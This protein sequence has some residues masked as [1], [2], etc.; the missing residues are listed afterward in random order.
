MIKITIYKNPV[1]DYMGFQS[2]GHAGYAD[3][4]QDIVC[5]AVS[6]LVINLVNSL[7]SLT[8]DTFGLTQNEDSG[9]IKVV[10][11]NTLSKEANLLVESF[12]L[13][14][15]GIVTDYGRDYIQLIFEEV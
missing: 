11:N 15:R 14:I 6:V 1:G 7:D 8:K 10:F 4:G 12:L 3:H 13:G 5:A 2:K 9:L